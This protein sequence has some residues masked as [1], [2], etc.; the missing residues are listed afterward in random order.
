MP[1]H[2]LT[3]HYATQVTHTAVQESPRLESSAG[4]E[5]GSWVGANT[6]AAVVT[7]Q[8][9]TFRYEDGE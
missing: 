8:N 7:M 2:P 6:C 5:A 1:T 9:F 4:R 3:V